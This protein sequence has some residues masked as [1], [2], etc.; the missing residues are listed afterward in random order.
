MKSSELKN[1]TEKVRFVLQ[2]Y[3]ATR[4]SDAVL[5]AKLCEII[6]PD[7]L[8]LP[9]SVVMRHLPEYGLP[10]AETV[11]RTRQKLQASHPE[12]AACDTVAAH[13][14]LNEEVFREYARG[15]V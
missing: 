5:Y 15:H 6:N 7:V 9:F 3:P 13:R 4:N 11:R 10:A 14:V 8:R 12:L 1:T 2:N